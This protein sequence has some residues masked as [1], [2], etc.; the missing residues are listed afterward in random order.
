MFFLKRLFRPKVRKRERRKSER[1]AAYNAVKIDFHTVGSRRIMGLGTGDDISLTGM[2]FATHAPLKKGE[3]LEAILYFTKNFPGSKKI[4]LEM[5]VVRV[6]KPFGA[7]RYRV[8]THFTQS[9]RYKPEFEV[10]AQFIL[11]LK[12]RAS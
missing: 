5:T 1:V 9:P 4:G 11:W 7:R 6:Y 8:G 2:R 10:M 12:A 3:A